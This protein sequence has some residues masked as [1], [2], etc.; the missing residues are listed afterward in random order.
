[1]KEPTRKPKIAIACQGGGS[2][3]AFTAGVLHALTEAQIEKDFDIVSL[4]G[5][6][7]GAVCATL[8][9][10]A[11]KKGDEQVCDRLLAF[12][13]DNMP[14]S[15][16]EQWFNDG[17]VRYVKAV[18]CGVWP[19]LHLSPGSLAVKAM[20]SYLTVG[21]RNTFS[22]FRALLETHIDFDEIASW[23]PRADRPVLLLGAVNVLTGRLRKFISSKEVIQVEHVLASCAVPN[24]FPAVQIDK[25]AYWDGLFSD[26]PPVDELIR[27][28]FVG[29][30]NIADE[31]WIIKIN[32]TS[33]DAVPIQSD[34]ILD[35]RTQLE[36]NV[37]L[38]QQL[39]HVEMLNDLL[40]DGAFKDEALRTLEITAPVKIPK[41][42]SDDPDKPYHIPWIEMSPEVQGVLDYAGKIDRGSLN[43][44]L[45]I[46]DG[47]K[48]GRAF[49]KTRAR[50]VALSNRS[51]KGSLW[52]GS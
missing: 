51:S 15:A 33:W 3:T 34:D 18:H 47:R 4:S 9:W 6:S 1:M 29:K 28:I 49:L 45:L 12:W 52:R 5:T 41:S 35:R 11:L 48:Q 19:M 31:I 22:D 21:Q 30:Q 27:P 26:N 7:G 13:H 25:D 14:Q 16:S 23:G 37:S 43:I 38:F 36:G 17:I 32:P 8:L 44:G 42:F 40:L 20:M 10:Y 50:M 24:I 2:Q 46:E 39:V